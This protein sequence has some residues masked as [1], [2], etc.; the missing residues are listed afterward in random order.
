[1]PDGQ[2]QRGRRRVLTDHLRVG[3]RFVPPFVHKLGNLH[4][5]K[6]VDVPL[7]EL[8]WLGL[9]N[10]QHGLKRGAELAIEVARAAAAEIKSD[11]KVWLGP[12]SAYVKLTDQ[13]KLAIVAT[14]ESRHCSDDLRIALRPLVSLYPEC[15]LAFLYEGSLPQ[16]ERPDHLVQLKE[17]L[18]NLFDKTTRQATLMQANAIYIAFATDMLVVSSDTSLAKF[19]AVA[20]YPD[21]DEGRRV[22]AAVR[23]S[24]LMFF[25]QHYDSTSTWPRYFWNR[26]LEIDGCV[27]RN[28]DGHE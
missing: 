1:M 26:G 8:L 3:Q 23:A 20:E 12:I 25:G 28:K 5:V 11:T 14:L 4:E 2:Q 22:G 15:P 17:V 13:A 21:T 24:I 27:F 16:G 10:H 18:A 6:W 19:P 7:P 9:L